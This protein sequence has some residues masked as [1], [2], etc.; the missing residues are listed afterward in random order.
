MN[1][2]RDATTKANIQ[3]A[4]YHCLTTDLNKTYIT[5]SAIYN[6]GMFTVSRRSDEKK[7]RCIQEEAL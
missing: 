6:S 3:S 5:S 7:A 1:R 2:R 4:K